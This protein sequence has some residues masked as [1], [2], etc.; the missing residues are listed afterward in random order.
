MV[1]RTVRPSFIKNVDGLFNQQ[2]EKRQLSPFVPSWMVI[3]STKINQ[4]INQSFIQS[5][6]LLIS[7]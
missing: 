4:S 3:V 1:W 5:S 2:M 6:D 7:V